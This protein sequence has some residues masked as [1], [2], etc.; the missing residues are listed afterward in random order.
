VLHC[1][2]CHSDVLDCSTTPAGVSTF[3][4]VAGHEWWGGSS[5][6]EGRFPRSGSGELRGLGWIAGSCNHSAPSGL[7]GDQTSAPISNP[8]W[9]AASGWFCQPRQAHKDWLIRS[10]PAS[11]PALPGRCFCGGF[12]PCFAPLIAG[13]SSETRGGG[14]APCAVIGIG[15]DSANLA[16]QFAAPGAAMVNGDHEPRS[17]R[18]KEGRQLSVP[19][20]VQLLG[21]IWLFHP[22]SL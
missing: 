6:C 4:L 12:S 1:G 15:C 19:H 17:R 10:P 9:W 22:E 5:R 3:P 2:L 18:Q 11:T 8:A 21:L 16:L 13:D 20:D 14:G 7:G